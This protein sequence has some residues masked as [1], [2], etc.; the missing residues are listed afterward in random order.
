M[1][2]GRNYGTYCHQLLYALLLNH[3]C[4][5]RVEHHGRNTRL[6]NIAQD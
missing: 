2:V 3:L 1:S 4:Q 6:L 5:M